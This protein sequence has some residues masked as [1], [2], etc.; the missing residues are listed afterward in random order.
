MEH[1]G[2][3]GLT[4]A[5]VERHLQVRPWDLGTPRVSP[6]TCASSSVAQKRAALHQKLAVMMP[7]DDAIPVDRSA[8]NAAP[9]PHSLNES[10]QRQQA[11]QR[12][13]AAQQRMLQGQLHTLDEALTTST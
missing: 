4:E 2:A 6:L 1:A 12:Q 10:M 9:T 11:L 3:E 5:S 7:T 13:L 8:Q